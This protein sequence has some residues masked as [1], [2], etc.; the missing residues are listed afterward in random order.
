M[1]FIS[2]KQ[3]ATFAQLTMGGGPV[4]EAQLI[5]ASSELNGAF[6]DRFNS[7]IANGDAHTFIM[8]DYE[9][10]ISGTTVRAWISDML[11]ENGSWETKID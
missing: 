3:D 1:A 6:P 9:Y 4:Y 2:S 10:Q 5:E 11:E 7:L 8:R